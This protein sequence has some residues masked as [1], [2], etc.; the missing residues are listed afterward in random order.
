MAQFTSRLNAWSQ[1][2]LEPNMSE[3]RVAANAESNVQRYPKMQFLMVYLISAVALVSVSR[4]LKKPV[5]LMQ[6]LNDP[7]P[8][9]IVKDQAFE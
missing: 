5:V 9:L 2:L 8:H 6:R 4:K 1:R 3:C 7:I